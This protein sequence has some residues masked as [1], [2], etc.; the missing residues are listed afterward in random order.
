M[1]VLSR[2]VNE[3]IVI[4]DNIRIKVVSVS[5]N[6]IRLGICAPREVPVHRSEIH[7]KLEFQQ[8]E[9]ELCLVAN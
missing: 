9:D 6:Q 8:H 5:G 3:E 1:L 7:A 4:G 2:K